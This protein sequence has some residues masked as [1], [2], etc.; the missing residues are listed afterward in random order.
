MW[1]TRYVPMFAP[2]GRVTGMLGFSVDVTERVHAEKEL[3]QKVELVE[4]QESAIRSLSTPIMRAF[5]QLRQMIASHGDLARKLK[6]L[7]RKYDDQFKVVFDAINALA[8]VFA[9]STES[10][11]GSGD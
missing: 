10:H 1:E 2:D 3:R 9:I 6:A 8:S 4:Q 7:E 5:V 11:V